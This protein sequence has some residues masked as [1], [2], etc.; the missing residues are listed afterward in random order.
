MTLHPRAP[1]SWDVNNLALCGFIIEHISDNN[2]DI[3]STLNNAHDVYNRLCSKH[4]NCYGRYK[5][6]HFIVLH[7]TVSKYM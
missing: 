7:V 5:L 1:I 2:Y 4:Q 3:V 6:I